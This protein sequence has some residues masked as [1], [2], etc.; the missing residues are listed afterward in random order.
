MNCELPSYQLDFTTPGISPLSASATETQA[1]HAEL[2]Q[3]SARA[4][5]ELAPVVLAGAELRLP[6]VFT[7]F[8]VV[9]I[10][11][12]KKVLSS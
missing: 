11:P 1:A 2:A 12:S 3:K 10:N 9:A 7:L 8:A 5:A 4:S 6:R